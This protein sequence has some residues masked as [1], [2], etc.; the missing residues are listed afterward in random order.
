MRIGTYWAQ[1]Q[2]H[3]TDPRGE[4]YHR[5]FLRASFESQSDAQRIADEAA[6]QLKAQIE[7]GVEPEDWYLYSDRTHPEPI[8]EEILSDTDDRIGALSINGYGAC[9]I[10]TDRVVFIDIDVPRS[11]PKPTNLLKRLFRKPDP[12]IPEDPAEDVLS[13]LESY[14]HL[15]QDLGARVYKTAAG[16]R[17]LLT[18]ELLDPRDDRTH[19]FFEELG[20]DPQYTNLCRVQ[21]CFRAR[22]TPKPVRLNIG[23]PPTKVRADR[24][25]SAELIAWE[26]DYHDESAGYAVC[27]LIVQIGADTQ[28]PDIARIQ[29]IH[30]E[31]CGVGTE[32]PLA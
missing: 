1:S 10:N 15:G 3:A 13:K 24:D 20:A 8:V 17:V 26:Q 2:M 23:W 32:L 21:S 18:G 4:V 30:D 19:A 28:H 29:S 27:K 22:L 5:S 9:I 11:R 6:A 14:C 16:L 12:I 7:R 31:Y 25:P